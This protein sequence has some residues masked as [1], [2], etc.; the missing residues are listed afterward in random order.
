MPDNQNRKALALIG[1]RFYYAKNEV[2][3]LLCDHC[4]NNNKV[5]CGV[6]FC[7]L[8]HCNKDINV[9]AKRLSEIWNSRDDFEERF[10]IRQEIH[11]RQSNAE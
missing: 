5:K 9:L 1:E 8:P 3:S 7:I 4:P 10:W 6:D 11:R 2:I